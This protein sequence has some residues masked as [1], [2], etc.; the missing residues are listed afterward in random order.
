VPELTVIKGKLVTPHGVIPRGRVVVE[1]G[2]ITRV[3]PDDGGARGRVLDFREGIVAPGF[4]DLHIHGGGGY[5]VMDA[6][7]DCLNRLSLFLAAGGVTSFLATTYT[8]PQ[9]E[10]L[11]AAR[12][13]RGAAEKGVEGAEVVGLHLEGPYINPKYR[14]SQS[15]SY[16][17]RP[18]V[19][20]LE[21]VYREAGVALKIV[22]LAPEVDG[23]LEAVAWLSSKGVVPSAGHTDAT[24]GEMMA[25]VESGLRHV[26]HLFNGM[27]PFHHREPG[28]VGAALVDPR[29]CVELIADGFHLHPASLSIAAR[30]KGAQRTALVS[31][32]I[33]PAGLPDG[34]YSLGD[35]RVHV[36]NGRCLLESG[37]PAGSA[38][39]LSDAVMEAV[40]RAGL[41]IAE[42]VEMASTTPAW[43]AGLAD[44]KGRLESG[45][46]ADLVVLDSG[47]KVLMTMVGG[48][49]VYEGR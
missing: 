30:L 27:R 11:A 38:I 15:A 35:E 14:G 9:D 10:I 19:E 17:R 18:N 3:G 29:V 8:A 26:A 41:P 32:S 42:A 7:A 40:G 13:V 6:S 12:A 37:A 16:I 47:L 24:Y 23:A 48:R 44:R 20:E 25:A 4:I 46:D 5:D 22:T 39:R 34:D 1:G 45:M 49:V 21:E 33:P 2:K 36:L 28:V 31:D 43:V